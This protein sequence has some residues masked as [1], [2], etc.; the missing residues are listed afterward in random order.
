[1]RIAGHEGLVVAKHF[2]L[3]TVKFSDAKAFLAGDDET[4]V[5]QMPVMI[6]VI[7]RLRSRPAKLFRDEDEARRWL[8]DTDQNVT[9]GDTVII[10]ELPSALGR[11]YVRIGFRYDTGKVYI[12]LSPYRDCQMLFSQ[13]VISVTREFAGAHDLSQY[14]M[15]ELVQRSGIQGHLLGQIGRIL[16]RLMRMFFQ[17]DFVSVQ[18][19][20]III[21]QEQEVLVGSIALEMD[22]AALSR[23][24]KILALLGPRKA[25]SPTE[26]A[27]QA[28]L[29]YRT[30][31]PSGNVGVLATGM[32]PALSSMDHLINAGGIPY[33]CVILGGGLSEERMAAGVR[34]ITRIP[35]I[36]GVFIHVY[37]GINSCEIMAKGIMDALDECPNDLS[38]LIKMGG[39]DQEEGWRILEEAGLIAYRAPSSADAALQLSGLM[40]AKK[41]IQP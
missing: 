25:H 20:P 32:G 24:E 12:S 29:V 3:P 30:I 11:L 39:H 41:V 16:Y 5:M 10:K 14:K 13:K 15:Y 36:T 6:E 1:M 4:P 26:E 38:V 27:E 34:I 17:G 21:T 8:R 22:N 31:D 40:N 2:E 28:G 33:G 7:P 19:S 37:G 35:S 9:E 23:Q 18:V